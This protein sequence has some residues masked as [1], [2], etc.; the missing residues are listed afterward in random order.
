MR[1]NWRVRQTERGSDAD[2][3]SEGSFPLGVLAGL[4]G[5]ILVILLVVRRGRPATRRGVFMGA[6]MQL[7]FLSMLRR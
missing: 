7:L 3:E 5:G 2:S 1:R 4:I 6:L